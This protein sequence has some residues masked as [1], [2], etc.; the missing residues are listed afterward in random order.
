MTQIE[1]TR[2]AWL[3]RAAQHL[4]TELL[5]DYEVPPIRI[6][7]GWPGGGTGKGRTTGE[8][9]T[10]ASAAD[11]VNQIFISPMRGEEQTVEVLGTLL[12]EMLHAVDDC[13][14]G[15][16]GNFIVLGRHVGMK[17]PWTQ[18]GHWTDELRAKLEKIAEEM[19]PF[20]NA[21]MDPGIKAADAP[22]PQKNRQLKIVCQSCDCI[23]RMSRSAID[24]SGLPTCGCGG[25]FEEA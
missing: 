5:E 25:S 15:H 3:G 12:H 16:T 22:A 10:R 23:A 17:A 4:A 6:S 14:S 11:K 20:P 13:N 1:D 18:A 8:C 2:E 7:V 9:W 21:A 24:T 19:T